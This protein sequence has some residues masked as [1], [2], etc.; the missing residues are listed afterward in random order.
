MAKLMDE[1][2]PTWS[3]SSVRTS[4]YKLDPAEWLELKTSCVNVT[5]VLG[6]IPASSRHK[7]IGGAAD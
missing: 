7:G 2:L 4:V 3:L 6:S 1:I 5:T